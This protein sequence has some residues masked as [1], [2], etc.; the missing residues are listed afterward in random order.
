MA[1]DICV[2]V[3]GTKGV[4]NKTVTCKIYCFL[5]EWFNSRCL[6]VEIDLSSSSVYVKCA[7]EY[8]WVN[9]SATDLE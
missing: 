8:T 7:Y 5:D 9:N 6:I 2:S 4:D 1:G 3:Y